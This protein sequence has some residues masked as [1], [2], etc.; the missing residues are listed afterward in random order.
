[1]TKR[2][3]SGLGIAS[4]GPID[5]RKS[6]KTYGYITSTP[7]KK[8]RDTD[9]VTPFREAFKHVPIGFDTDVNAPAMYE[10]VHA[11]E[12][13]EDISSCAYIT[14][15][16]GVGVGLVINGKNV[17]GLLHPEAGHILCPKM[18]GDTF[19]GLD[20][21]N[22]PQGVEAHTCSVALAKQ[23]G[24]TINDLKDLNDADPLW[25][26]AAYHIAVLCVNLVRDFLSMLY[27]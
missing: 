8:W 11:V 27:M 12:G 3:I 19:N 4:F 6:S 24:V 16:T 5:P 22:I 13:G 18:P 21:W 10:Y 26:V 2:S 7:K 15:G 23:A 9:L 20:G 25:D 1:M 14:V 17:H